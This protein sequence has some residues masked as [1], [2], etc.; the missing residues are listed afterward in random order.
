MRHV[1]QEAHLP[2]CCLQLKRHKCSVS[3][4]D[5]FLTLNSK[6]KFHLT[7]HCLFLHTPQERRGPCPGPVPWLQAWKRTGAPVSRPSSPTLQVT[8]ARCS[9]SPRAMSS[10]C[11]CPKPATAGTMGRMKRTRCKYCARLFYFV[12]HVGTVNVKYKSV[13]TFLRRG[14]FPFSYTRV[15]PESDS[16]KLKVKYVAFFSQIQCVNLMS[17]RLRPFVFLPSQPAPWE[18]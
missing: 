7:D 5:S 11:W 17:P 8:T 13:V 16:E 14:W 6:L 18:K 15:L 10:P 9:A 1:G 4:A 2:G 12:P 3:T